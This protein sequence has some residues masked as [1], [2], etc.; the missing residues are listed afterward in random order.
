MFCKHTWKEVKHFITQSQAQHIAE[1]TNKVPSPQNDLQLDK[2]TSRKSV[3]ILACEKC[4][5]LNK[6]I[7]NI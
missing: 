2:M 6:T 5:K 4:G 7:I 1:L 3:T